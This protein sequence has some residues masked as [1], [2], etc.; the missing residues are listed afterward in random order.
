MQYCSNLPFVSNSDGFYPLHFKT[1]CPQTL[2]LD[3]QEKN[4]S[5]VTFLSTVLALEDPQPSPRHCSPPWSFPHSSCLRRSRK[6]LRREREE[7]IQFY[8]LSQPTTSPCSLTHWAWWLQ[9]SVPKALLPYR[10]CQ[11]E[12]KAGLRLCF[13]LS[14]HVVQLRELAQ[15]PCTPCSCQGFTQDFP[16]ILKP[17]VSFQLCFP[18]QYGSAFHS[19]A[20]KNMLSRGITMP[21]HSFPPAKLNSSILSL[22]IFLVLCA[23][24]ICLVWFFFPLWIHGSYV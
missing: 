5:N 20:W 7:N 17:G 8:P 23:P 24:S 10:C 16:H 18:H 14:V 13:C 2:S 11:K 22:G 9:K 15:V 1:S 19:D 6:A 21:V 3:S 4:Q 12:T